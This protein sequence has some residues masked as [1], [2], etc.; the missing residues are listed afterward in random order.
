[1]TVKKETATERYVVYN[2]TY[3]GFGL[4]EKAMTWLEERAVSREEMGYQGCDLWRHD[5]LLAL[6]VMTLGSKEASGAHA[7]L[8]LH[9]L[10]DTKY[11]IDEYDGSESVIEPSTMPWIK[12]E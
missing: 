11:Y 6:C 1:M 3:G 8:A 5:Q 10:T 12:A 4:S 7:E 9:R 2:A